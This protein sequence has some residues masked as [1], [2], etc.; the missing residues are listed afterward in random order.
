MCAHNKACEYRTNMRVYMCVFV[1]CAWQV[2]ENAVVATMG[3]DVCMYIYVD[4]DI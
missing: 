2:H 1:V 3:F 4:G